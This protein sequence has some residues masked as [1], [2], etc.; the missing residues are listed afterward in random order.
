MIL[1]QIKLQITA[2]NFYPGMDYR[3][4]PISFDKVIRDLT[5]EIHLHFKDLRKDAKESNVS[6]CIQTI[7]E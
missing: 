5:G 4:F 3:P 7:P 1:K 6:Y 2:K